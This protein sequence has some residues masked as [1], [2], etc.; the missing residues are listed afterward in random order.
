MPL[1]SASLRL[2]MPQAYFG[3]EQGL[4][5]LRF[6][7]DDVCTSTCTARFTRDIILDLALRHALH[8]E[9]YGTA[10][11]RSRP[12]RDSSQR[13]YFSPCTPRQ[14][15]VDHTMCGVCDDRRACTTLA[16]VTKSQRQHPK[17]TRAEPWQESHVPLSK[18]RSF[19]RWVARMRG[20]NK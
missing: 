13:R 9:T 14:L 3:D 15:K 1:I 5:S 16:G 12:P 18:F 7:V 11:R 2:C 19:T 6:R 17:L 10:V 8:S 4:N 20:Q